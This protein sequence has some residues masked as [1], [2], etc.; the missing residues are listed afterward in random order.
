MDIDVFKVEQWMGEEET[1]ATFNLGETCID[2]LT[3]KELIDLIGI[4]EQTFNEYILNLKLTYGDIFGSK[5]L[6]SGIASLYEKIDTK[7]II[8]THGAIGANY[9]AINTL[10]EPSDNM[11]SV[12]PTYQQHYSIPKS[13]GAE[14]RILQL[15]KENNYLPD[16]D[17]L[18][19]L[20]DKNT[21]MITINTPNNPTG[22]IMNKE[23]LIKISEIAKQVDAYVL[24]DE[25]YR[26]ISEDDSY[27]TSIVDVYDKGIS[28]G[29]MSKTFSLAGIRLGWIV[30]QDDD[31]IQK[32]LLRR[33]YDTISLGRI[34]DYIG[35][36]A[37]EHKDKIL[38]RNKKIV[39]ENRQILDEWV[40]SN[41]NF[42]YLKPKGGTTAL[43]YYGK[44]IKSYDLCKKLI[45]EYGVLLTPGSCFEM[46][47]AFRI[48]YA[49]DTETLKEGLKIIAGVV[50]SCK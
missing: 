21:K 16:M 45:D 34:N 9:Q 24:S 8:P 5:K 43:I 22:S 36:I 29:S 32:C 20:V 37:L 3:V 31:F 1:K 28:V 26:G 35:A 19:K 6:L 12:M 10:I 14:V 18:N 41:D 30:S 13:I 47:G 11:V 25:V 15:K 50:E 7:N 42:T 27:I 48:G 49:C 46:E 4:S 23:S 39:I 40:N 2:S 33:D 17:E 44:N 38:K